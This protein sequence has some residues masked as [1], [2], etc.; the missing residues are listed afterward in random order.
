MGRG[1][2][3]FQVL[4]SVLQ[5]APILT[6]SLYF[7]PD[8]WNNLPELASDQ[9][10]LYSNTLTFSAGP[11]VRFLYHR[12]AAPVLI[13]MVYIVVYRHAILLNRDQGFLVYTYSQLFFHSNDR[14]D[15]QIECVSFIPSSHEIALIGPSS[16]LT[17]P[18]VSGKYKF[19]SQ[20]PI[21]VTPVS[22]TT[23]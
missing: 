3:G 14:Q 19:G 11:R 10:G 1:R 18:Y 2:L 21:I 7:S 12:A 6:E 23:Q 17:R 15:H 4:L 5:C 13:E 9:P 22:H 8:R 16:V 20:C